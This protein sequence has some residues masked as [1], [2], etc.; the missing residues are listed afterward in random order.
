MRWDWLHLWSVRLLLGWFVLFGVLA[1]VLRYDL[2]AG[3][4][5][6]PESF[7]ERARIGEARGV[8]VLAV[9]K[10]VFQVPEIYLQDSEHTGRLALH[11]VLPDLEGI[12]RKN[13][14]GFV[15]YSPLSRVVR[16]YISETPNLPVAEERWKNYRKF[17]A[18]QGDNQA[19]TSDE[20]LERYVFQ[21]DSIYGEQELFVARDPQGNRIILMCTL[22]SAINL[23]PSCVR[24]MGLGGGL[25]LSYSFRRPYLSSWP[26]LDDKVLGLVE[27]FRQ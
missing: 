18:G 11:A 2:W 7:V 12:T 13:W 5:G 9:G 10:T 25:F 15:D 4:H 27:R 8:Q 23:S 22:R 21:G 19:D 20:A 3:I 1:Y 6:S 24:H 16:I 26:E 17:F 14:D